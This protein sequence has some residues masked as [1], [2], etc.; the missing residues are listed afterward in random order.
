MSSDP[1]TAYPDRDTASYAPAPKRD[2]FAAMASRPES[3]TNTATA[4][5]RDKFAA[6]A[7]RG[8]DNNNPAPAPK[9]DKFAA[10][11]SRPDGAVGSNNAATIATATPSADIMMTASQDKY[12]EW[13]KLKNQRASVWKDLEEAESFVLDL[14]DQ[15]QQTAA[16][17]AQQTTGK[18]PEDNDDDGDDD[19]DDDDDMDDDDDDDDGIR[20]KKNKFVKTTR[21][22]AMLYR[23]TLNTIHDKLAPHAELVQ[24]Y[25]EPQRINHMYQARIEEGLARQKKELLSGMLRLEQQQQQ[26]QTLPAQQD[27]SSIATDDDASRKRSIDQIS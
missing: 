20:K 3:I 21:N 1:P 11:A 6:M 12:A 23:E 24:A 10:M 4:P 8:G 26:Q 5:K 9:R 18:N 27:E 25:K 2:K 14:L 22:L 13:E 19:D 17:L 7:S 15:A 16:V